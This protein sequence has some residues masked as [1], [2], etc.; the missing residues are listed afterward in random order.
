MLF[1]PTPVSQKHLQIAGHRLLSLPQPLIPPMT[2]KM[3]S[4]YYFQTP[5]C[6]A[7]SLER[8]ETSWE[9]QRQPN[10]TGK[11]VQAYRSQ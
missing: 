3:S 5:H 7:E 8:E 11:K 2:M 4:Y 1:S 9:L 10:H 6:L